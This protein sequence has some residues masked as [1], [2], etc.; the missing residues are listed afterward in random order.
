MPD[1]YKYN[2][3]C[4]MIGTGEWD[5]TRDESYRL[6]GILNSKQM[7]H[8]LD[9]KWRCHDCNYWRDMLPYHLSLL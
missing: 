9:E 7:K 3:I 5:I 1:P 4:I 2:Q 6:S 8:W